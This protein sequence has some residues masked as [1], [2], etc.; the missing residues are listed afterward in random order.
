MNK[1]LKI[2][3]IIEIAFDIVM[4]GILG[5]FSVERFAAGHSLMGI[6]DIAC[7]GAWLWMAYL[8]YKRHKDDIF[9]S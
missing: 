3:A 6:L 4:A 5:Y 1:K 8:D 2:L 9:N 7:A